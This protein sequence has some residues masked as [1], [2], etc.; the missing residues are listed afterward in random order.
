MQALSLG[1]LAFDEIA[2]RQPN[3]DEVFLALTGHPRDRPELVADV[4]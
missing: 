4:A 3:L 2:L 1:G